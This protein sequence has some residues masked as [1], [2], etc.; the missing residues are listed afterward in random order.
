MDNFDLRK[1]LAENK[2]HEAMFDAATTE[3]IAQ[4]VADAFTA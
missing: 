4:Q 1:F 2:L 3:R